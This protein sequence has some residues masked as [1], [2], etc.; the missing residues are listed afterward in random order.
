LRGPISPSGTAKA[1]PARFRPLSVA[2]TFHQ[3]GPSS[4][5]PTISPAY[6]SGASSCLRQT[7]RPPLT[8]VTVTKSPGFHFRFMAHGG[9]VTRR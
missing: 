9:A 1:L 3:P 2:L 6:D 7:G 8:V 4:D 5:G